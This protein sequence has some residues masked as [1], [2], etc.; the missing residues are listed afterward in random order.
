MNGFYVGWAMDVYPEMSL[1]DICRHLE[2]QRKAGCNYVWAGHNNPGEAERD[3]IEPG[4][5]YA[6]YHALMDISHP[7]H[8]DA[9]ILLEG[10]LRFLK[11]CQD[12]G[13]PIVF[14][15]GYQI[16]MG[17]VWNEQHPEHLRTNWQGEIV[18]WGGK[19]ACFYSPRYQ[20]DILEY[21]RWIYREV[22]Q[23]YSDTILMINLADEPFGGDYSL[24]ANEEFKR[25]RGYSFEEAY[26]SGKQGRYLLGQFQA[27]YIADY[28]AWSARAWAEIDPVHPTTMSF[29]GHHGREDFTMPYVPD[30]FALTPDSFHPTWDV[31]PRDGHFTDPILESDVSPLIL[32]LQQLA[33]QSARHRRPYWLWTTGNS[34]GLGQNSLDKANIA[35]ALANQ[36]YVLAT[37]S[38][39][40]SLLQGIGIWNYNIKVQGLYNDTNPIIYDPDEMFEKL[41]AMLSCARDSMNQSHP[42]KEDPES[43]ATAEV[44]LTASRDYIYRFAGTSQKALRPFPIAWS[45]FHQPVKA[46]CRIQ[47]SSSAEEALEALE[48]SDASPTQEWIWLILTGEEDAEFEHREL[49][50]K[51]IALNR[52]PRMNLILPESLLE[53][54]LSGNLLT[55]AEAEG[56]KTYASL[57]GE[58]DVA[59]HQK[60]FATIP[61]SPVYHFHLRETHFY[62]NLTRRP[63]PVGD[64]QM[65][66]DS[67]IILIAP[68]AKVIYQGKSEDDLS[69]VSIPHHGICLI[70]K[71]DQYWMQAMTSICSLKA[72]AAIPGWRTTC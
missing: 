60:P 66:S 63:V 32:F 52:N 64:I 14:P 67:A 58:E 59:L 46:D 55:R 57:P 72:Q 10:Q 24:H 49:W 54:A 70:G 41:S 51:L 37:A 40:P 12:T 8:E 7:Q 25:R 42:A 56:F 43:S 1:D 35:D 15:V 19:S 29:C 23:P 22:I 69:G 71:E 44:F 11:A 13:F 3:K 9:R 53:H 38:R 45:G 26:R 28:A 20:Q 21:Y 18:N 2:R 50:D 68:E 6:I 27:Q 48:S 61:G 16:Q 4:M 17:T 5:S 36:L 39:F 62:Y 30:V 65:E 47:V 31:Y 33:Y 34:W